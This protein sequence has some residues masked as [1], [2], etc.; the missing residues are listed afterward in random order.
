MLQGMPLQMTRQ[1]HKKLQLLLRLARLQAMRGLMR[2]GAPC[3]GCLTLR[4]AATWPSTA[5]R[6]SKR[7][8]SSRC[9]LRRTQ[10]LVR[11]LMVSQGSSLS[12][13]SSALLVSMH[14]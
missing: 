2:S 9:A 8:R 11:R 4:P 3:T 14:Q 13:T 5:M 7:Q 6:P 1:H 12:L 10:L